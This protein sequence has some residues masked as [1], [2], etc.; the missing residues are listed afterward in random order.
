MLCFQVLCIFV[1]V[2]TVSIILWVILP[3]LNY[4]IICITCKSIILRSNYFVYI[5]FV[6]LEDQG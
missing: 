5:I 2:V 4:T 3:V 1:H 6:L